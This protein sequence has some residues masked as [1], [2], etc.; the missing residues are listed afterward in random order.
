MK[1]VIIG[2]RNTSRWPEFGGSTWVRL[3]YMLGLR[4]LGVETFWVDRLAAVDPLEHPH[5][6]DYLLE[7]F[8]RTARQFDFQ[9]H[10][11]IVYNN[12]EKCFGLAEQALRKL[13]DS[14]DLLLNIS[15]HLPPDSSLMKVPRRAYIDVDC[16]RIIV[17]STVCKLMSQR[18]C[19]AMYI[20]AHLS[21]DESI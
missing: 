4:Q 20:G 3:Q 7:R 12:G 18:I 11:C 21:V 17:C 15:G 10:Y 14:A 6:L 8:E 9:D 5:T 13:I 2:T 16:P 1:K 19:A